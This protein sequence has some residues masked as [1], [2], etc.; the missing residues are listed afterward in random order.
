MN[1]GKSTIKGE[2]RQ[3]ILAAA[4]VLFAEH[5]VE[6][7]SLRRINAEAGVSPGV[8]HYHFGSRE[9][10][11]SELIQRHMAQL[12]A[13]RERLLQPLSQEMAQELEQERL[14]EMSQEATPTVAAIVS[15]LVL[16]LARF[17]LQGGTAGATYVRLLAR[18]HADRSPMLEEVS[19]RYQHIN[20]LYPAL[21][22][23]ALPGQTPTALALRLAMANHAMMQMLAELT[24]PSRDGLVNANEELDS[25]QIIAMLID[26]ISCG[27]TGGSG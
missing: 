23:R 14:Q 21:L 18:L 26:F 6:A 3:A 16:P 22:Q 5:G 8:L 1:T 11:V 12:M 2:A 9:I 15:T 4:E 25:E 10:L 13:E 24:A 7:V 17:A 19:Q 27:M 20:E